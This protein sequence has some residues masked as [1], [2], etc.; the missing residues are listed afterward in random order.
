MTGSEAWGP[1]PPESV[2]YVASKPYEGENVKWYARSLNRLYSRVGYARQ[3]IDANPRR[4][5]RVW[6]GTVTWT[7]VD[8]E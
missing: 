2:V 4:E 3:F 8:P 7:E 6:V 5:H 1:T